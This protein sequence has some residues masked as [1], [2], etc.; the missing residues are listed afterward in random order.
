MDG[1][2]QRSALTIAVP[3]AGD[4]ETGF[5]HPHSLQPVVQ[6]TFPDNRQHTAGSDDLILGYPILDF[7]ETA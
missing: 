6:C 2:Y 7:L 4:A 5:L 1:K 3:A